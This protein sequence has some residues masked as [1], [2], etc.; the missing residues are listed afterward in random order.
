MLVEKGEVTINDTT[1]RIEPGYSPTEKVTMHDNDPEKKKEASQKFYEVR[2][3][4]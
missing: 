4:V 1:K 3:K 2:K